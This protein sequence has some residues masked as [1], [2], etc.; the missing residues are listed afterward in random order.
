[1]GIPQ[2]RGKVKATLAALVLAFSPLI[3]YVGAHLT[4]VKSFEAIWDVIATGFFETLST[5]YFTW[6][7]SI[8]GWLGI[9][10][11]LKTADGVIA[12]VKE[13]SATSDKHVELISAAVRKAEPPAPD[14]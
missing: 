8:C 14:A 9:S 2:I 13:V 1:M 7:T 6:F 3:V 11:P 5:L 12:D 10:S 4:G